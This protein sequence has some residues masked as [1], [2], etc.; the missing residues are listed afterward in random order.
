MSIAI[1]VNILK[2]RQVLIKV[3]HARECTNINL[4][5]IVLSL[6]FSAHPRI[7][8]S[9]LSTLFP[10]SVSIAIFSSGLEIF[11]ELETYFFPFF[12]TREQVA[13][14]GFCCVPAAFALP[15]SSLLT[16]FA[17]LISITSLA[18]LLRNSPIT[19]VTRGV[20]ILRFA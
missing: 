8:K 19:A 10:S 2:D 15:K 18:L 5:H 7:V 17:I 16:G 9:L 14:L 13:V 20:C 3:A 1:E 12:I 11:T 6:E 4:Q